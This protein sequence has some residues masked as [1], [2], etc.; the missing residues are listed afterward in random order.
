MILKIEVCV[1]RSHLRKHCAIVAHEDFI[2]QGR[3]HR[4]VH[5]N[6]LGMWAKHFVIGEGLCR[7]VLLGMNLSRLCIA[8]NDAGRTAFNLSR[9]SRPL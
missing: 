4:T 3:H 9:I 8:F 1:L 5:F 6:L 2:Q 7:G